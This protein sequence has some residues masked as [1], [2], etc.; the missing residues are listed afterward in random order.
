MV[1]RFLSGAVLSGGAVP[2]GRVKMLQRCLKLKVVV[3]L[4]GDSEANSVCVAA[5][6]KRL[7]LLLRLRSTGSSLITPLSEMLPGCRASAATPLHLLILR[8]TLRTEEKGSK[9]S[10]VIAA[11]VNIKNNIVEIIAL[12]WTIGKY[13]WLYKTLILSPILSDKEG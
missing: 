8:A 9:G 10:A 11:A 4:D 6:S 1:L 12:I 7:F 5:V 2:R 3:V 13:N